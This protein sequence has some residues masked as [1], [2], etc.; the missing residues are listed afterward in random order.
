ML[1]SCDEC[2][3]VCRYYTGKV[4]AKISYRTVDSVVGCRVQNDFM[5]VIDIADAYRTV[6]IHPMTGYNK[7]Y[8][9]NLVI[10]C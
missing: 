4:S 5:A 2:Y 8:P 1:N 7:V 3:G 10:M 9:G 6:P